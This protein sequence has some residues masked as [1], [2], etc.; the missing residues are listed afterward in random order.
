MRR[1]RIRSGV[2][3]VI[4][5][6][7]VTQFGV[8]A[9]GEVVRTGAFHSLNNENDSSDYKISSED[10]EY[11]S[12]VAVE[13]LGIEADETEVFRNQSPTQQLNNLA[14]SSEEVKIAKAYLIENG[15]LHRPANVVWT[16]TRYEVQLVEESDDGWCK[17]DNVALKS[18]LLLM[19]G[20]ARY[21]VIRSPAVI[22]KN[23]SVRNGTT[24][25]SVSRMYWKD[26]ELAQV[27]EGYWGES[28]ADFSAGDAYC[29]VEPNVYEVYLT[30]ML[31]SG[32]LLKSDF[33]NS[34]F[35]REY[36]N[37]STEYKPVW[38]ESADVV[39][40]DDGELGQFHKFSKDGVTAEK[41]DFFGGSEE[42][43]T[44]Y[45]LQVIEKYLR[46]TEKDISD[47][48]SQIVMFKYGINVLS[49][50]SEEEQRTLSFLVAKGVLD[51]EEPNFGLNLFGNLT[52][53]EAYVLV[54]RTVNP[55]ARL[56][57]SKIQLTDSESFWSARGFG[58]E[59]LEVVSVEEQ[60]IMQTVEVSVIQEQAWW[61]RGVAH[62][63]G[64]AKVWQIIK[65]FDTT[66]TY[67]YR[68]VALSDLKTQVDLGECKYSEVAKVELSTVR[69][70]GSDV[71]VYVVTFKHKATSKEAAINFVD[72]NFTYQI[73]SSDSHRL[74][75][76]TQIS[77]VTE[78]GTSNTTRMI[79]QSSLLS[80]FPD[81]SVIED[82]VLYNRSTGAQ[83]VFLPENGYAL[84]GNRVFHNSSLMITDTTNTVYYNLSTV[85][86]LLSNSDIASLGTGCIYT[87]KV[88]AEQSGAVSSATGGSIG[89]AN[90]LLAEIGE[91]ASLWDNDELLGEGL[92]EV[93]SSL[94]GD[95]ESAV[96]MRVDDVTRGLNTIYR[97]FTMDL[98]G[99][100]V[101]VYVVVDWVFAA[102]N[103]DEL[104]TYSSIVGAGSTG[105]LTMQDALL[106]L[107]TRPS[108]SE[109]QAW[110]DSNLG[111]SNALANFVYGTSSVEYVKSGYL[112]P[113][114][115]VLI[116][117][118][119]IYD[120]VAA[121]S[122]VNTA[123]NSFFSSRGFSLP[124]KYSQY[125]GGT[126][127]NFW[128]SYFENQVGCPDAYKNLARVSRRCQVV[129]GSDVG[130]GLSFGTSFF[131]SKN[132]ILYRNVMEDARIE[133]SL[134]GNSATFTVLDRVDG[135][136]MP[137]VGSSIWTEDGVLEW[138]YL[139]TKE[140]NGKTYLRLF[141][142]FDITGGVSAG[143]SLGE[144][145]SV[146]K[147]KCV[148][149]GTGSGLTWKHVQQYGRTL[150]SEMQA[151][152]REFFPQYTTYA[153][154]LYEWN[155]TRF[156]FEH[157][158][159]KMASR[160]NALVHSTSGGTRVTSY[161]KH[162]MGGWTKK[163]SNSGATA[164]AIPEFYL[165]ANKFFAYRS[166]GK[167]ELAEGALPALLTKS[168][169]FYSGLNQSLMD[170]MIA[171]SVGTAAIGTL[172]TGSS[173]VIDNVTLTKRGE[174][175]ETNPITSSQIAA[176]V[177]GTGVHKYE[178]AVASLF[179]GTAVYCDGLAFDVMNYVSAAG[180]S[181]L[182]NSESIGRD[183][184]VL[185]LDTGGNPAVYLNGQ[186]LDFSSGADAAYTTCLRM[187]LDDSLL[188]RPINSE[189]TA[190]VFCYSASEALANGLKIPFFSESLSYDSGGLSRTVLGE[191][192]YQMTG[193]FEE[194][195]DA[196]NTGFKH[197]WMSNFIG[198]L[199]MVITL[200]ASY[201]AVISL[202]A[203]FM[204]TVRTGRFFFEMLATKTKEGKFQ[205]VDL[206]KIFSFGLYSL[207]SDPS[208][209]RVL[210]TDLMC[211]VVAAF[212]LNHM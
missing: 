160:E 200:V 131:V 144:A 140:I 130:N 120:G 164:Y 95:A 211:F 16:G 102:P 13:D 100:K 114:L 76:M 123:L 152:Y 178:S 7:V 41:P 94:S 196:S 109:L 184:R 195:K 182:R 158:E 145:W 147:Y 132:G 8:N 6:V 71:E 38:L 197:L 51:F 52:Y 168:N 69:A 104:S 159:S 202:V 161:W 64:S 146:P 96:L 103:V 20:K 81:I 35:I 10:F 33:S 203:Y 68:G 78:D 186:Y 98:D 127:Q 67:R 66:N 42:L 82:K 23:S 110:W 19:L 124:S 45:A 60:P 199:L 101:D 185:C 192:Y 22:M 122:A 57:F 77:E 208:L 30:Q 149:S 80:S 150:K 46:V 116:E 50:F 173:I 137:S 29:W 165:P 170:S 87:W 171:Q 83:A 129:L 148:R 151:L 179:A 193:M 31:N 86:A 70:N 198:W 107:Y 4:A 162:G 174:Y 25:D 187:K 58:Q 167:W 73:S 62:A 93:V 191:S 113:S 121:A 204:L 15:V 72:S 143:G 1:S 194:K 154:D 27:L 39:T 212:C 176:T 141:P 206:I 163:S 61:E 54:Y 105:D 26:G 28:A 128:V 24:S 3:A 75:A 92:L 156:N 89:S 201:L 5:G 142:L 43:S 119:S 9:A 106:A 117:N 139:G 34:D 108:S 59:T 65:Q 138:M 205:G 21:G 155:G 172:P 37:T 135:E 49:K 63:A 157:F 40:E 189:K 180:L 84:V 112:A 207:D 47:T 210:F 79:S 97:K 74:S 177:R 14:E 126:T 136:E 188:V 55:D 91:S 181:Q 209:A 99:E 118:T 2:A 115:T 32:L 134:S 90:Y 56:D 11:Y 17:D 18:D 48:E 12:S 44:M 36:G 53:A 190:W 166:N 88:L 125:V 175:W 85:M 169:F 183:V 111:M 133:C 153:E